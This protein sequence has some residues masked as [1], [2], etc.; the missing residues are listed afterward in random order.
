M[1]GHTDSPL[2]AG[3]RAALESGKPLVC[4]APPAAWAVAPLFAGLRGSD[5]AG[6]RVLV[7][8]PNVGA[9]ADL[10]RILHHIAGFEPV[11]ASSGS[12][13]ASR[14]LAAGAVRTL[15]ATPADAV[16]LIEQSALPM[17][18]LPAVVLLGADALLAAGH[19][20]RLDTLLSEARNAQRIMVVADDAGPVREFLDRHARRAPVAA[21]GRAP[22]AP[23]TA[24]RYVTV[25]GD[26]RVAAA[27]AVL[28]SLDPGA[29]L[30]WEPAP[31]R[32]EL[33]A[34]FGEDPTI[35]IAGEPP[36]ERRFDLALAADVPGA[37]MLAR[38][39]QHA[40]QVVILIRADQLPYLERLAR[41]LRALR[42]P[43]VL[44]HERDRAHELRQ[45]VRERIAR[46][47]VAAE[48]LA[49]APL[50]DEFDPALVAAALARPAV[51]ATSAAPALTA[52]VKVQVNLGRRD[53]VRPADLV[54]ALLN[55][56][57]LPKD[58]VGR[59]EIRDTISEIDIRVESAPRA[60]EGLGQLSVRGRAL[61]ARAL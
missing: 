15:I 17:E 25:D 6:L 56:V 52:W 53:K 3:A 8:V 55:G 38:L 51:P 58:H 39:A 49:L 18:Q 19:G 57:G 43:G 9:A 45:A 27:R 20:A 33:W 11:H 4:V 60:I 30:L 14:L 37:E 42:V 50:F 59:I 35:T 31:D 46:G 34:A 61:S 13:R 44:D 21:L 54:G 2:D 22:G 32:I 5:V 1:A 16:R 28:D 41:P 10:A 7:L 36:A 23:G 24:A 48:L 12:P 47:D 26:R 29:T 40:G